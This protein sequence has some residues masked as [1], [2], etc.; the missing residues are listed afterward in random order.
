MDSK[1]FSQ[2]DN[3]V[4]ELSVE[5][6]QENLSE[7]ISLPY[8]VKD[9]VLM[10]P[11]VWNNL[12]ITREELE[13]AFDNT[14]WSDDSRNDY[15]YWEHE[16]N[17]SRDF[18][19]R[20]RNPHMEGEDLIG[21][22]ELVDREAAIK[23]AYGAKFGISPKITGDTD[24]GVMKDFTYDN[25]SVVLNPAVKTT[26]LNRDASVDVDEISEEFAEGDYQ[27]SERDFH[28]F[29]SSAYEGIDPSES[30]S[31]FDQAEYT[32]VSEEQVGELLADYYDT[33]TEKIMDVLNEVS[34][35]T[36]E[37][38]ESNEAE[39]EAEAE[40]QDAEAEAEAEDSKDEVENSEQPEIDMEA[41]AQK[42]AEKLEA[43][44]EDK[45]EVDEEDE[46]MQKEEKEYPYPKKDMSDKDFSEFAAKMMEEN[47]DMDVEEVAK[48]YKEK[49]KSPEDKISEIKEEFQSQIDEL[50]E[51]IDEKDKKLEEFSE[52]VEAERASGKTDNE[53]KEFRE[54][55]EDAS[56]KELDAAITKQILSDH[57]G[58]A[59][60]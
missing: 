25:F 16:D 24:G 53:S 42:V 58:M 57:R 6:L 34:K 17:D 11:G 38:M 33:K 39:V 41:L 48:V 4:Q 46:D 14:V 43:M 3:D 40:A 32:G 45:P 10:S 56:M 35:M 5:E 7:E 28:G 49:Q 30:I 2:I 13:K 50:K 59:S 47:P 23:I 20:V 27:V 51:K 55:L 29:I 60:R 1:R 18:V 44:Q 21:D 37:E 22:L 36:D 31:F 54:K 12:R 52:K 26:F 19:G 15:I 8:V 9:A